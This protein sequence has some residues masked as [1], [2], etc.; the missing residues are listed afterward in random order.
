MDWTDDYEFRAGIL[1]S[2]IIVS[3]LI[4]PVYIINLDEADSIGS[5]LLSGVIIVAFLYAISFQVRKKG[6]SIQEQLWKK[7]GGSPST[8]FLRWSDSKIDEE[9]KKQLYDAIRFYCMF[10]LCSKDEEKINPIEADERIKQAFSQI[11][12]LVY[13]EDPNGKW[14]KYNAEYGFNRNLL[15]CRMYWICSAAIGVIICEIGWHLS[16][17]FCFIF[18]G[19]LDLLLF[20]W[21]VIWSILVLPEVVKYPDELYAI[22]MWHSFLVI[23]KKYKLLVK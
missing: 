19:V 4:I 7:F 14:A 23:I 21:A 10:D 11:K 15:G 22:S 8:R 5:I 13:H 9:S 16:G 3:P 6:S 20:L 18:G 1:P 17:K 12:P 2:A